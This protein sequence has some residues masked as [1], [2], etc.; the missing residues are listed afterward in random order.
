MQLN[1]TTQAQD[2]LIEQMEKCDVN[3][4]DDLLDIIR[5]L[6][7]QLTAANEDKDKTLVKA[8]ELQGSLDKALQEKMQLEGLVSILRADVAEDADRDC[9]ERN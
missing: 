1:N 8:A 7:Q 9:D 5:N 3:G 2:K 4:V 6:D